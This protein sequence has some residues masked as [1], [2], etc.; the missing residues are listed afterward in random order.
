MDW[1]LENGKYCRYSCILNLHKILLSQFLCLADC[2]KQN[3]ERS[4][5]YMRLYID[6][7]HLIDTGDK[8]ATLSKIFHHVREH[9]LRL[10]NPDP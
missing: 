8:M 6:F 10:S 2:Q 7:N 5:F 9:G 3:R 4:L 1:L